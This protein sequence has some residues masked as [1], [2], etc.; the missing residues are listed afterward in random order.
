M[1][2]AKA[3]SKRILQEAPPQD[4]ARVDHAFLL[5][6]GRKP[7]ELE[8]GRMVRFLALQRDE[9]RTD[10]TAASLV[11]V[12]EEVYDTS[13]GQI[14][15]TEPVVERKDIP[16]LAAWTGVARVLFNLDDFMT[17]E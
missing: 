10:P 8:R 1:E 6:L 13:P 7:T 15:S 11:V 3:L 12:K 14:P 4:S 2:F 16:E 9:Y 17:R 5:T